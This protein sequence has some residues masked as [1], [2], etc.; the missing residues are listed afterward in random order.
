MNGNRSAEWE[1]R[2]GDILGDEET[3]KL[4]IQKLKDSGHVEKDVVPGRPRAGRNPLPSGPQMDN[5]MCQLFQYNFP[6]LCFPLTL[7]TGTCRLFTLVHRERNPYPSPGSTWMSGQ[8]GSSRMQGHEVEADIVE[9]DDIIDLLDDAE[10]LEFIQFDPSVQDKNAWEAGEVINAFLDDE[11]KEQIKK[12]GKNPHFGV[13]QSLF[14][15]PEQILEMAGPLTCLWADILSRRAMV[16]QDVLLLLQRVLVQ[17]GGV[18]HTITQERR[19]GRV[20]PANTLP[21]EPEEEK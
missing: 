15:L 5:E 9:E 17:L 6:S 16:K 4:M 21:D 1:K 3:R 20:N 18:S 19:R 12:A 13:E 14:K 2:I 7:L 10:A 11:I 8:P